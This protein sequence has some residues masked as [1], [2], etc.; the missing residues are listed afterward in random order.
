[1]LVFTGY[2]LKKKAVPLVR[3]TSNYSYDPSCLPIRYISVIRNHGRRGTRRIGG[4]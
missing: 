4:Y 1:M 3:V 2:F